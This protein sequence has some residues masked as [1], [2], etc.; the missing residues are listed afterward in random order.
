M[1][2]GPVRGLGGVV[3]PVQQQDNA[4]VPQCQVPAPAASPM[5]LLQQVRS[6]LPEFA[7]RRVVAVGATQ[8]LLSKHLAQVAAIDTAIGQKLVERAE[9]QNLC[10]TEHQRLIALFMNDQNKAEAAEHEGL[11]GLYV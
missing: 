8:A 9:I 2:D 11:R 10:Q 3:Q 5:E 1:I 6:G 4:Q 7:L